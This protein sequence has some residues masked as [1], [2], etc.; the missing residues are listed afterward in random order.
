MRVDGPICEEAVIS[1]ETHEL[2]YGRKS[3]S[4][5]YYLL[6]R[7]GSGGFLHWGNLAAYPSG[8]NAGR[9]N[10]SK[11]QQP[12]PSR[13]RLTR[14]SKGLVTQEF[15]ADGEQKYGEGDAVDGE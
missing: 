6:W 5:S 1:G 12:E 13:L 7:W 8:L 3:Q 15:L 9:R 2:D 11:M 10:L 4:N 14:N